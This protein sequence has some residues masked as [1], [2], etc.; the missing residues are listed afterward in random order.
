MKSLVLSSSRKRARKQDRSTMDILKNAQSAEIHYFPCLRHQC[1][2]KQIGR[3]SSFHTD[4]WAI[5]DKRQRSRLGGYYVETQTIAKEM[6]KEKK[7]PRD[8]NAIMTER[9]G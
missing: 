4:G 3:A 8:P 5:I 1:K 9:E 7:L 6:K 2:Y